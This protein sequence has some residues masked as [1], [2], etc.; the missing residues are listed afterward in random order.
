MQ[1]L[2]LRS[3]WVAMGAVPV[4]LNFLSKVKLARPALLPS[5]FN[6]SSAASLQCFQHWVHVGTPG[7]GALT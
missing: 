5:V 6:P 2:V 7:S 3:C 1:H 4:F